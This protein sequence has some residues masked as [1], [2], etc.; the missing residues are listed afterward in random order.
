MFYSVITEVQ[1]VSEEVFMVEIAFR[2]HG[3]RRNHGR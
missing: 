2:S 1:L 3:E